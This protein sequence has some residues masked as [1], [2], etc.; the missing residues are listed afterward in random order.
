MLYRCTLGYT[1][2]IMPCH[3]M[4]NRA[5]HDLHHAKTY[6]SDLCMLRRQEKE[7]VAQLDKDSTCMHE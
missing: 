4:A 7:E 3:A 2:L 5:L 1:V 6:T